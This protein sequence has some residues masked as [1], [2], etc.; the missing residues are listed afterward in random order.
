[1]YQT[2]TPLNAGST[3]GT[4]DVGVLLCSMLYGM[5]TIQ[6][7][8][9]IVMARKRDK[10]L[11]RALILLIWYALSTFRVSMLTDCSPRLLESLHLVCPSS[12]AHASC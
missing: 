10:G 2:N 5:T 4:I 7:Y 11:F 1:M 6:V 12:V 8:I 3:L 9:Y